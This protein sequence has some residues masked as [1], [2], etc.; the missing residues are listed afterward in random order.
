MY[1]VADNL[2]IT[3]RIE[4]I[5]VDGVEKK[6]CYKCETYKS[7]ER[8]GKFKNSWDKLAP[9]CNDCMRE[10]RVANKDRIRERDK[11]YVQENM[12]AH[13]ERKRQ[14]REANRDKY[15]AYS[16]KWYAANKEKRQVKDSA[17][18]AANQDKIR[19]IKA[20][21]RTRQ[22]TDMKD[23]GGITLSNYK[24]KTRMSSR[25]RGML[26]KAKVDTAYKYVGCSLPKLRA[27][28]ESTFQEYMSFANFNRMHIDHRIP[29][30]AFDMSNPVERKACFHY[31]NLQMLWAPDNIRK[32][33]RYDPEDK[34]RYMKKFVEIYVIP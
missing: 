26:G 22:Y 33:D 23:E 2:T 15:N 19:A 30:A 16:K 13:N 27:S 6:R 1:E 34:A 10:Y 11:K 3:R 18:R 28:L 7:L 9:G 14:W 17:Y 24:I 32:K 4:H 25:I 20:K 12:E 29:C 5:T 21:Y 8:F 31:K